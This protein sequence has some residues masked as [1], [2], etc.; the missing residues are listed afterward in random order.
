MTYINL[1]ILQQQTCTYNITLTVTY[2][3]V[4]SLIMLHANFWEKTDFEIL[5]PYI[6]LSL[7][8]NVKHVGK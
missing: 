8:I 7:T 3:I 6:N 5:Y 1:S 2:N 4:F